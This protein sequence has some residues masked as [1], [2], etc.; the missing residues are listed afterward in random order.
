MFKLALDAGHGKNTPGKRCDKN[1]DKNETREWVL[2][3][4]ICDYVASFL[5]SYSGVEIRRMD[6]ITGITDVSLSAR[7]EK[8]NQWGADFYLSVHHDAGIGGGTGGGATVYVYEKS[9]VRALS[10]QTTILKHFKAAVGH[11]GNRSNETPKANLYV[12]RKTSMPAVL[13]EC[14]F[15]DS[16][17]DTPVILTEEFAK[18]AARGLANAIVEIG[19]LKKKSADVIA[20]ETEGFPFADVKINH[21]ARKAIEYCY[22]AGFINGVTDNKF[23]PDANLTRAQ[24][25]QVLYNAVK[26][27]KE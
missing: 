25:C 3:A 12:L 6:D 7:V 2:N 24:L 9:S 23:M 15:M 16:T 4:R 22:G 5:S 19:G 10:G 13:I 1:I 20:E 14:G 27:N 8:A 21:W 18:K 11:F 17:V 26:G